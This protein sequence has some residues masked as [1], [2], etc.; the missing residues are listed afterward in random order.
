V[1]LRDIQQ[2]VLESIGAW[3]PGPDQLQ[4]YAG[5][6]LLNAWVL[7]QSQAGNRA[8]DLYEYEP[9]TRTAL[10]SVLGAAGVTG[11]VHLNVL[12]AVEDGTQFDGEQYIEVTVS[13]LG[14]NDLVLLDPFARWR[15]P[16]HQHARNVYASIIERLLGKAED[17]PSLLIFWTWGSASVQANE[18]LCNSGR[19]VK[20]GYQELLGIVKKAGFQIVLVKWHWGYVFAMWII[21]PTDHVRRLRD[22]VHDNCVVLS[23]H[24]RRNGQRWQHPVVDVEVV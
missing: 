23:D 20:N 1:L 18:D 17:S 10:R 19:A 13:S 2:A 9:D 16:E 4:W 5:S 22:H 6:A 24:L 21:V 3:P 8:L 14:K 11:R 15:K 12:P 7:A